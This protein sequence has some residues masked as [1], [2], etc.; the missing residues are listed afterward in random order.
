MSSETLKVTGVK[1]TVSLK[2]DMICTEKS[3]C[4]FFAF[5]SLRDTFGICA[6]K[7]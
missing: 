2:S 6:K 5:V 3:M 1:G 7:M 4:H